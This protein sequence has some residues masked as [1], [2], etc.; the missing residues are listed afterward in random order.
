MRLIREKLR[1]AAFRDLVTFDVRWAA[2]T[3]DLLQALNETH[4]EVVHFSGHGG[5]DGLLLVG[6]DGR[7]HGVDGDA[8]ARLFTV[9][10]ADIRVVVLSACLTLPQAQAIAEAVGCAIGTR[11]E[12]S[13]AAAIT[14][15]ASFY[16]AI[17]FG[18]S[19]QVAFEQARMALVLDHHDDRECPELVA[20]PD[21]DP[22]RLVLLGGA[23]GHLSRMPGPAP[24]EED[25]FWR[26]FHALLTRLYP[27]GPHDERVWERAGGDPS[28][29]LSGASARSLWYDAVSLIRRGG[30]GATTASLLREARRDYPQDAGLRSLADQEPGP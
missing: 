21:V 20:R 26:E 6:K 16:R 3:D 4:P 24:R 15:A 8:L 1:A 19:V 13:D 14:F 17:A 23:S 5:S 7:P 18:H 10:P 25:G 2:R 28:R 12:I 30:G 9:F 29:L 11:G 22:A 27:S